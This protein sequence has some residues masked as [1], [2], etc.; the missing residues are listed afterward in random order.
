ME[1]R[2]QGSLRRTELR[3]CHAQAVTTPLH[4][5]IQPL[6]GLLGTWT[7]RGHGD[8]PTIDAFDYEETVSF[9]HVGKPFLAYVQRTTHAADGRPL[10]AEAGYLRMAGPDLLELVVSH[11][12]GVTEVAEGTLSGSALLLRSTT[13][14]LTG[15]AKEVE[16]IERDF[17]FDGDILRYVLRMSAVGQPLTHHLRAELRR[18][19]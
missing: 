18:N 16:A 11:P 1:R 4:P 19:P 7:G 5:D 10:H 15:S 2:R 6:A 13:I 9:S 3:E 17:V 12:T 8:Y 14:G